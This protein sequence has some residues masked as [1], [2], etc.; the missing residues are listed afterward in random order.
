[1]KKEKKKS[2]LTRIIPYAGKR[3]YMLFFGNGFFGFV[4]NPVADAY[5]VYSQY[6]KKM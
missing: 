6:Y 4:G 1:M 2:V 5:V 3:K